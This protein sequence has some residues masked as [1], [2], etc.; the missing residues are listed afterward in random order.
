ML[1]LTNH[2]ATSMWETSVLDSEARLVAHLWSYTNNYLRASSPAPSEL[3]QCLLLTLLV[4]YPF[5]VG[6]NPE[7]PST[8]IS[9]LQ[10]SLIKKEET[11]QVSV[12]PAALY[13]IVIITP[14][15]PLHS[16]II[17]VC[18]CAY[19]PI[20]KGLW[21]QSLYLNCSYLC[22]HFQFLAWIWHIADAPQIHKGNWTFGQLHYF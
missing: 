10:S 8:V 15:S 5:S 3:S 6:K 19:T 9:S 2:T 21:G 12:L 22:V 11:D 14:T 1:L 13:V 20:P 7:Q 17:G 16:H 4:K 18:I